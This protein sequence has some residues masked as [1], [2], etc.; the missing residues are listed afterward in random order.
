MIIS[1]ISLLLQFSFFAVKDEAVKI[2]IFGP[3]NFGVKRCVS[4]GKSECRESE[5]VRES[6][7]AG[8]SIREP[9][10]PPKRSIIVS[11]ALALLYSSLRKKA[12]LS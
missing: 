6:T 7:S 5:R 4:W 11:A 3:K 9:C 2:T 8:S 12:A 10:S 1:A